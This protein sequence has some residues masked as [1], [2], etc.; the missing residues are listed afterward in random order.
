MQH[1]LAENIKCNRKNRGLTQE[2]LAEAMGVTVGTVSKW[3]N[4][5]CV[6][7]I[8][9]M[10]ELAD[11]FSLSMDALVGFAMSSQNVD[12]ILQETMEK[13][14]EHK[15]AEARNIVEK[16]MIRYPHNIALLKSA[17]SIYWM[18]WNQ[19]EENLEYKGKA[20][21]IFSRVLQ[22]LKEEDGSEID[23]I[24]IRK[25]LALLEEDENKKLEILKQINVSGIYNDMIAELL[26]N[27]GKQEDALDFYDKKLHISILEAINVAEQIKKYFLDRKKY[28]EMLD[29]YHWITTII[30]GMIA[31]GKASYLTRYLAWFYTYMAIAYEMLDQHAK[32]KN[33]LEKSYH[34]AKLFDENPIYE[35]YS[36]V[37][38]AYGP[39]TDTP[40]AYDDKKGGSVSEIRRIVEEIYKEKNG[41]LSKKEKEA[42]KTVLNYMVFLEVNRPS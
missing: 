6:P 26:W 4:G 32:M 37:K 3:E 28:A 11:F 8:N 2:Q 42:L 41:R 9:L 30:S 36:N 39:K 18:S 22:L 16:A 12:D 14:K 10:M 19:E 29:Y 31:D 34:E 1:K 35:I 40:V 21:E 5:N 33:F 27:Q 38:F 24:E 20:K 25:F 13:C 15:L 23:K 17:G 7:D